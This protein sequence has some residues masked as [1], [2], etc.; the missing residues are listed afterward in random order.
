MA[1]TTLRL[2]FGA[3]PVEFLSAHP[4]LS[5]PVRVWHREHSSPSP[6][7][8]IP[9]PVSLPAVPYP[10]LRTAIGLASSSPLSQNRVVG[11]TMLVSRGRLFENSLSTSRAGRG[12]L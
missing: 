5:E 9:L 6:I 7:F 3:N 1:E 10:P 4:L 2:T 12:G 8:D 11:W